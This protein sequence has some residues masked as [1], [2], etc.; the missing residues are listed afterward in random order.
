MQKLIKIC[1]YLIIFFVWPESALKAPFQRRNNKTFMMEVATKIEVIEARIA[2]MKERAS[3][4]IQFSEAELDMVI[5]S[6]QN[7]GGESS[8]I[9]WS[10]LRELFAETAHL[11]YKNWPQT[12]SYA[13]RLLTLLSGPDD[14]GFC[15]MF[16]RVL[17]DGGW[18]TAAKL[19]NEKPWV[20]L[21]CGLN[22]I[23]KTTS[24][25]QPWFKDALHAALSQKYP[26][27]VKEELPSGENAFFR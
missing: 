25:Y 14:P 1:A 26:E 27:I 11:S 22:G 8:N 13:H 20:V 24:M 19:T 16:H 23:R 10:A 18:Q 15:E 17:G 3:A 5:K 9:D 12:E 21:V 4:C 2:A 6:L 7:V